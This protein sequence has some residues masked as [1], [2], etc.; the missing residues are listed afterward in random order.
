MSLTEAVLGGLTI[1]TGLSGGVLGYR[2]A[3]KANKVSDKTADGAAYDRAVRIYEKTIDL[4]SKDLDSSRAR[5]IKVEARLELLEEDLAQA[6]ADL[7]KTR[8]ELKNTR[9]RMTDLES[10]IVHEGLALPPYTPSQF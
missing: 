5:N 9:G 6:R 7:A 1:F 4:Q 8:E 2:Q 10:F 3:S